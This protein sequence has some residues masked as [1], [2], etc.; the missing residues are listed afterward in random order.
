[1]SDA[2][3]TT[4]PIVSTVVA[5]GRVAATVQTVTTPAAAITG[6]VGAQGAVGPAGP[7]GT[8]G[9]AISLLDQLSDVVAPSPAADD[10]LRF[11]NNAWRNAQL[12]VNGGNF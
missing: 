7:Q 5:P 10:V 11:Q 3:I 1:L 2:T 8:P 4:R 12:V 6:G 9:P